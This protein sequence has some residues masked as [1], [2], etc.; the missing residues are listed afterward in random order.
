MKYTATSLQDKV[1]TIYV[2]VPSEMMF[3]SSELA[4]QYVKSTIEE[5]LKTTG[6][7]SWKQKPLV[8]GV[9]MDGKIRVMPLLDICPNAAMREQ[10]AI[11]FH[12]NGINRY[13]LCSE[14]D[15]N[16][17]WEIIWQHHGTPCNFG[18]L[19]G[20]SYKEF[21]DFLTEPKTLRPCDARDVYN[22]MSLALARLFKK[23][24]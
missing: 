10:Y 17:D 16:D 24:S 7:F 8:D 23:V 9:Y 22:Q 4:N 11:V 1:H 12:M 13:Q 21:N 15:P 6:T 18:A 3:K 5:Y 2:D 20:L 19:F 14:L